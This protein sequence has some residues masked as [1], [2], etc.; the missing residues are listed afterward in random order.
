MTT[1]TMPAWTEES[2][3]ESC[4]RSGW[5]LAAMPEEMRTPDVCLAAVLHGSG[6]LGCVPEA[7]RSPEICFAAVRSGSSLRDVPE[8]FRTERM[9]WD[10]VRQDGRELEHVPPA[11]RSPGLCRAA[12]RQDGRA[13]KFV[14]RELK[15]APLCLEAVRGAVLGLHGGREAVVHAPA[16]LLRDEAFCRACAEE[17]GCLLELFH[18]AAKTESVCKAAVFENGRAL[19]WVPEGLKTPSL[20][21]EAA[22]QDPACLE[23][24][25]DSLKGVAANEPKRLFLRFWLGIAMHH[26]GAA[27]DYAV[28]GLGIGLDDFFQDFMA[29]GLDRVCECGGTSGGIDLACG[30][31]H[32][33]RGIPWDELESPA[34]WRPDFRSPEFLLGR[35]LAWTQW[36]WNRPFEEILRFVQPSELAVRPLPQENAALPAFAEA[37]ARLCQERREDA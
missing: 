12:V 14:P 10:A 6:V 8:A 18:D 11:L 36:R 31:L 37:L 16:L 35:A 25:P 23:F 27:L 34:G 28:N 30:V 19:E 15:T 20:C 22:G 3:L 7:R 5:T 17:D 26:L 9:C 1:D 4:R 32:R 33:A 2:C 21:F 29:S 24:V 13:L